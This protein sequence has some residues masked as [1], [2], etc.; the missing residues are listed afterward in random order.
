MTDSYSDWNIDAGQWLGL[1]SFYGKT[2]K[3]SLTVA[4]VSLE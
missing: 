1:S 2:L 3:I 4:C